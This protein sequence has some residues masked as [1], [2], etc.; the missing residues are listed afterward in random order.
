MN[1]R[2][3]ILIAVLLLC[4]G[5]LLHACNFLAPQNPID[6]KSDETLLPPSPVNPDLELPEDD[7]EVPI[8]FTPAALQSPANIASNDIVAE[9]EGHCGRSD[10]VT[11]M[12]L[13]I[14]KKNQS[15]SIRLIRVNFNDATIRM[16]SIPRDFYM[17][18]VGFEQFGINFGRINAAFGYG[19][20]FFGAGNGAE[21]TAENIA[22]N[23]GVE[24]D[25]QFV[26]YYDEIAKY[27][28]AIGGVTITLDQPARDFWYDFPAGTYDLDG[29]NAVV[30]MRI[31][32]FDDD[33]HRIDRQSL[34]MKAVLDKVRSGVS[35]KMVFDVITTLLADKT[36]QTDLRFRD[37]YDFYCLSKELAD[38]QITPIP[39]DLFHPFTTETGAQVLIPHDGVVEFVQNAL[40]LKD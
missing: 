35:P 23:F 26:L 19:E 27:I 40:A 36:T 6:E 22:Y 39:S 25:E 7:G 2:K 21:A 4:M 1:K 17:P 29:E 11:I 9:G 3:R 12:L 37:M 30:I 13:G 32:A 18:T 38:V 10:S 14:D 24:A 15:D 16:T 33:I 5:L 20:Y 34:V 8:E 31:R 28:D